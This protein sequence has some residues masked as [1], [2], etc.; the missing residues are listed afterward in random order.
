MG[1]RKYTIREAVGV[2]V[3][4]RWLLLVPFA[5][6]AALA[7]VLARYAPERFRSEALIVVV[8]QQVP[9]S[10]V[11]P[12]VS[13]SVASRLPAITDQILS[14]NKLELII[15][16]MDL[17]PEERQRWVMEDVVQRMRRDVTTTAVG[18]QVD[19]FR[20]G[21]VSDSPEKARLVTDRLARLYMDQNSADRSNQANMTSEFLEA[22]LAQAKERLIEQEQRLEDYRKTNAGQLPSQMQS[23]LQAIQNANVQLQAVHDSTNR[24]Q[25]RRLLIERQLADA[26][27][28]LSAAQAEPT[29]IAS[30]DG[31]AVTT[32][33]QLELAQARL[34][35]LLQRNSAIHPDVVAL[36]RVVQELRDRQAVEAA[37]AANRPADVPAPRAATADELAQ[38]RRISD[39]EAQLEVVNLQIASNQND[40]VRLQQ[41]IAEYQAKVDAVPARESELVD[42]TRDYSTMQAAY[43]DLLMK[44]E[45]AVIAANLEH[46]RIGEQFRLVDVASRPERPA[47]QPQRLAVM[48]SGAIAGFVLGVLLIG[49]LELRDSSFRRPEEVLAALSVPVL[50]SIPAMQSR[51]ERRLAAGRRLLTDA[52]GLAIVAAAIAV[53]AIWQLRP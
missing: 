7:P 47:N 20:I 26:R 5:L 28:L 2:L 27:A 43:T 30:A 4:R 21:Y 38:Q 25:E 8:P 11:Q 33:R 48:S 1:V 13:Q 16:E 52:S 41:R 37:E 23:N 32:S 6:G 19:S 22:Q 3:R 34:T 51:R 44:R 9:N 12:T 53:L 29:V 49:L 17:Y 46:R 15:Q 10:Y 31:T 50:A 45:N 42:L 35:L 24:A 18:R 39:L 40:V 14:R 36:E